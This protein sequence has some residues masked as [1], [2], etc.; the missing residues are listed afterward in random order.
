MIPS[1]ILFQDDF[2]LTPVGDRLGLS[3]EWIIND[4]KE[5][6]LERKLTM[7]SDWI[8]N[9]LKIQYT[10]NQNGYRAPEWS[11]VDWS[12]SIIVFGCSLTMG[13]G[14]PEEM[15]W[16]YKLSKRLNVPVIN[17]GVSGGSNVLSLYNSYRLVSQEIRPMAVIN[18]L[19]SVDRMSYFL[20]NA[21]KTAAMQHLGA[22]AL[23]PGWI[24]KKLNSERTVNSKK[25]ALSWY[26]S[27]ISHQTN[28]DIYGQLFAESLHNFWRSRGVPVLSRTTE[29][30]RNI[31]FPALSLMVD[32]GRDS[33]SHPGPE[34]TSRWVDDLESDVANLLNNIQ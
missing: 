17:L 7:P 32:K 26:S 23:D 22:W 18:L 3:T 16:T 10:F 20:D 21:D 25:T 5:A 8:F 29:L 2:L 1:N 31:N 19:T 28:I 11:D 6:F 33:Y 34:T 12:K 27:H 15:T 14:L 30:S 4:S 9:N 13:V 24:D